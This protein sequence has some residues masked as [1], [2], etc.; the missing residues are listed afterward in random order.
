M[1][2]F[3]RSVQRMVKFYKN[4][5]ILRVIAKMI[6]HKNRILYSCDIPPQANIINA[7]FMHKGFG[8]VISKYAT[9]CENSSIQH[10]VTLGTLKTG[11]D[12]P[13]IEKNCYIGAKA[14]ILG[15]VCIGEGTKIGAAAL[16]ITDIPA[17]ATAVGVPA[18]IIKEGIKL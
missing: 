7:N 3:N 17:G 2:S 1:N 6:Y 4:G 8:V 13:Y 5:G 18:K 12:A 10:G 11:A 15:N 16:V 9:I 14:T